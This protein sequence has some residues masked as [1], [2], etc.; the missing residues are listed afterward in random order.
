M[1]AQPPHSA[2]RKTDTS[3]SFPIN[4]TILETSVVKPPRGVLRYYLTYYQLNLKTYSTFRASQE[5]LTTVELMETL[6]K[7]M[8]EKFDR[9]INGMVEVKSPASHSH[10]EFN[11]EK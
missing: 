10:V 9:L 8:N 11:V 7:E 3:M 6:R 2:L 4:G 1:F 5:N